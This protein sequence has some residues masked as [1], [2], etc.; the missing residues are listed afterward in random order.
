MVKPLIRKYLS[1]AMRWGSKQ[2]RTDNNM[3]RY[4]S[5]ASKIDKVSG[6][7][8]LNWDL[9]FFGHSHY[10]FLSFRYF[11]RHHSLPDVKACHSHTCQVCAH[12][13]E[14]SFIRVADS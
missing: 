3:N 11:Q 4:E 5:C 9:R 1:S 7:E 14:I 8:T 12:D 10:H 13:G 6:K 2:G